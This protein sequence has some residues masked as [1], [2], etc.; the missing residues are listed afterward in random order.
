MKVKHVFCEVFVAYNGRK[1]GYKEYK[2]RMLKEKSRKDKEAK[3]NTYR[4]GG[5]DSAV[6]I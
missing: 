2:N 6:E 5:E 4:P 3:E 1:P